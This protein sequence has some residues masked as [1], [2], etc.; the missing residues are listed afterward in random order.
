MAYF[1]AD[2]DAEEL[3][4]EI[5]DLL[6]QVDDVCRTSSQICEKF[7]LNAGPN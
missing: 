3:K 5:A 7:D 1:M 4:K 2:V 6:V